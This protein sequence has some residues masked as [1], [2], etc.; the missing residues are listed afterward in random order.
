MRSE[1]SHTFAD[2]LLGQ[3]D[4][5]LRTVFGAPPSTGRAD[6]A[7]GQHDGELSDAERRESA[8]LM[9]VNHCGEV[10][11]Q[12]LYQGQAL[13]ARSP[14]VREAMAQAAAEENDHLIWCEQRIKALGSHTSYL[15]PLFYVGSLAVGAAAGLA[16]DRW[17]LGFVAE[18]E[19]Q[20]AEHLERHL[21][22][23]PEQDRSSRAI[24]EQMK[25]DESTHGSTALAA[26]GT[27]P[28][29]PIPQLMQAASKV[30]TNST[31]WI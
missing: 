31:Y 4:Q 21:Q 12:A 25:H 23:L 28:P 29:A 6:P 30:M 18:T 26:G 14:R 3:L 24:I 7:Q 19:Q 15:N 20:V 13:T 9:R 5:G 27:L 1:R 22:R 11:A 8:R 2:R 10:C 17:S 16:G